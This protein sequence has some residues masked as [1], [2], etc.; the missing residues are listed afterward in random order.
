MHQEHQGEGSEQR[1]NGSAGGLGVT[2]SV[3]LAFRW[4]VRDFVSQWEGLPRPT[5]GSYDTALNEAKVV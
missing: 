4:R 5:E 2:L 1:R 3:R